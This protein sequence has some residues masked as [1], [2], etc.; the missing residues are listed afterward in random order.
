MQRPRQDTQPSV[1][2]N[3]ERPLRAAEH[4]IGADSGT[5]AG[6]PPRLPDTKRSQSADRLGHVLDVSPERGEMP[7]GT[8]GKPATERGVLKRLRKVTQGETVLCQLLLQA[9]PAGTGLDA[10]GARNRVELKQAIEPAQVKRDGTVAVGRHFRANTTDDTGATAKGNHGDALSRAPLKHA[11]D[12]SIR[13]WIGNEVRRMVEMPTK[14]KHDLGVGL[15]QGVRGASMN[16]S[17]TELGK[18]SGD[19]QPHRRKAHIGKQQ[20]VL[21]LKRS[22]AKMRGHTG[23][24]GTQLQRPRLL[25]GKTPAPMLV[26]T[27]GHEF[28]VY[29]H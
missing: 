16:I 20:R 28:R 29:A 14:S 13:A 6:E 9:R 15:T 21:D 7:G 8:R 5:G 12:L 11:L 4:A 3:P 25:V 2:N 17:G 23:C 18:R 10:R 1:G 22:K 24:R 19:R 27:V 26:R